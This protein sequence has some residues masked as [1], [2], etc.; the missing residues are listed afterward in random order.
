MKGVFG[1]SYEQ[2][3]SLSLALGIGGLMLFM[4]YIMY[5]LA[6]ESRAGRF[7]SIMIF[8][9]LGLGLV[10]F[11]ATTRA[12]FDRPQS[13]GRRIQRRALRIAV[14]DRPTLIKRGIVVHIRIVGRD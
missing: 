3:A 9:T 2:F 1:L 4:A 11:I 5:R 12:M 13:A 7:G 10:D 6:R 14:P 8:V